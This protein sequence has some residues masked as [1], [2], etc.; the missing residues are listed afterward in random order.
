MHQI[1]K[2]HSAIFGKIPTLKNNEPF[3]I[4]SKVGG[5]L[6]AKTPT[7]IS[8]TFVINDL[9]GKIS[10]PK[11]E[12]QTELIERRYDGQ[13]NKATMFKPN[14]PPQLKFLFHAHLT[15]LSNKATA[16]NEMHLKIQYLGYPILTN[17]DFNY[18][19]ALFSDLVTN[20]KNIINGKNV[21]FLMF[22]RL[23]SYYLQNMFLK[24]HLSK[25][26]LLK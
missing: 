11:N 3:G 18:S 26:Q 22:L 24:K 12:F 20:L 2:I 10:F 17:T 6:V 4:T 16:F 23:L 19:Q 1:T 8:T 25:V 13:L 15:C 9:V 21:V 14:F 5:E 7:T